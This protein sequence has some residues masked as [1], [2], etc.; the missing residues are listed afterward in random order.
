MKVY[1]RRLDN[2]EKTVVA[3]S[4]KA[5]AAVDAWD[6][7]MDLGQTFKRIAKGVKVDKIYSGELQI[8]NIKEVK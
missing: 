8:T 3:Y 4:S 6:K 5:G 7:S 2:E 1:L